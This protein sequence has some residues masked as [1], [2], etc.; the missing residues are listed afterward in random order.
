LT[1]AQSGAGAPSGRDNRRS[2]LSRSISLSRTVWPVRLQ[3]QRGAAQPLP[4]CKM[5]LCLQ[6]QV[7]SASMGWSFPA[8]RIS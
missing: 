1:F 8:W 5:M 2:T 3:E 4:S 7:T 6:R